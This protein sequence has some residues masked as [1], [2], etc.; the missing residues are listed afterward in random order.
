[1][2]ERQLETRRKSLHGRQELW[3]YSEDDGG[4]ARKSSGKTAM[5]LRNWIWVSM[6]AGPKLTWWMALAYYGAP[7]LVILALALAVLMLIPK[8]LAVAIL[9]RLRLLLR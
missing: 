2:K 9:Q 3:P 4:L 6:A 8:P 7:V 1:M 5:R